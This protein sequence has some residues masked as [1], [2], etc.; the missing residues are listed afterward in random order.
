LPPVGRTWGQLAKDVAAFANHQGGM[1]VIGVETNR[2]PHEVAD[3]AVKVRPVPLS[4][5]DPTR[6]H[7]LLIEWIYPPIRD[8]Q[9]QWHLSERAAPK[10]LF[11]ITVP[12]QPHDQRPFIVNRTFDEDGKETSQAVAIPRRD[13]AVTLSLR[14]GQVHRLI[15]DGLA[16]TMVPSPPARQ[17]QPTRMPERTS[18]SANSRNGRAGRARRSTSYRRS[19]QPA[20]NSTTGT[21]RVGCGVRSSRW[22]CFAPTGSTFAPATAWRCALAG[23]PTLPTPAECFGSTLTGC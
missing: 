15:N 19:R 2:Q 5:I 3:V 16:P 10:G 13:G 22:T 11:V 14:V 20:R 6:Y 21:S 17:M 12:P 18:A 23:W 9:L 7:D 1:L 8:L 4:I